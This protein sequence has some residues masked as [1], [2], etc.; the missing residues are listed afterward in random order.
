MSLVFLRPQMCPMQFWRWERINWTELDF[1]YLWLEASPL[2]HRDEHFFGK[3]FPARVSM[4]LHHGRIPIH[5]WPWLSNFVCCGYG[6]AT[7]TVQQ[8]EESKTAVCVCLVVELG[9]SICIVKTL[10]VKDFPC[11]NFIT[12]QESVTCSLSY[13]AALPFLQPRIL[14]PSL[15]PLHFSE[16]ALVFLWIILEFILALCGRS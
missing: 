6:C 2:T 13:S 10:P 5:L 15:L 7:G 1:L 4:I 9:L 14:I 16:S 3:T 12:E 11:I 8:Q